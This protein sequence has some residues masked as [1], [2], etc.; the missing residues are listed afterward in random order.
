MPNVEARNFQ[1]IDWPKRDDDTSL[2]PRTEARS[3]RN[4][5]L[6]DVAADI[7]VNPFLVFD[8]PVVD[9]QHGRPQDHF[10]REVFLQLRGVALSTYSLSRPLI[11]APIVSMSF[12]N[13]AC[14]LRRETGSSLL[15]PPP[16][17]LLIGEYRPW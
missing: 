10:S 2:V 5:P 16:G 3:P 6:L 12:R 7:N 8:M 14:V 13:A 15:T 11:S 9:V 1:S 17:R 4:A